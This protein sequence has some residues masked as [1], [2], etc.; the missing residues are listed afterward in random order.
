MKRT[1]RQSA[2]TPI[3][4]G[5]AGRV[6]QVEGWRPITSAPRKGVF[7]VGWRNG[8]DTED[9][10]VT[11]QEMLVQYAVRPTHWAKILPLPKGRRAK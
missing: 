11:T 10:V 4:V 1:H 5:G 2:D 7:L 3:V 6:K 9:Y 8:D